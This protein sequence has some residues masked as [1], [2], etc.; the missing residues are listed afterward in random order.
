[1]TA[2]DRAADPSQRD[3]AWVG[4][5][6][7]AAA[8]AIL[9]AAIL[10]VLVLSGRWYLEGLSELAENV[11]ALT[12][13]ALAWAVWP[14]LLA[15]FLYRTVTYTYRLTDR[16]LLVDYGFL[17][18]R[19]QPFALLEVNSVTVGSGWIARWLGVG[20]VELRTKEQTLRMSG[21]RHPELFAQGIR[22]AIEALRKT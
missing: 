9:F 7:R 17:F 3:L 13:F 6:P 12:V 18:Y 22:T 16:A 14:G 21:V 19:I 20:W 2:G 5:H 11:G 1:M 10:N 15:V 8:P 4:Y